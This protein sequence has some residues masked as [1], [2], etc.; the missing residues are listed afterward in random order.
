MSSSRNPRS[1]GLILSPNALTTPLPWLR[2]GADVSWLSRCRV[3]DDQG[4]EGACALFSMASWAEI[5]YGDEILDQECLRVYRATLNKLGRQT[6]SGLTFS[7]AFDAASSAGWLPG[8][9]A[10]VRVFDLSDLVSQPIV[11]GYC[12]TGAL[13]NVSEQGCLDHNADHSQ[14]RGYHAMVIVAHGMLS[15]VVGGPWVYVENSWGIE[16]GWN[17]IG[18]MS[19]DLHA[20]LCREMWTI[21]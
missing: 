11:A 1:G 10:L 12:V 19:Q 8:A 21:V 5:M 17:G 2:T 3:G 9:S 20:K 14:I 6:G 7:E 13:D 15:D 18:L 16:W 4:S